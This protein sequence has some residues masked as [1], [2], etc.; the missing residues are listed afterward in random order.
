[1]LLPEVAQRLSLERWLKRSVR[2]CEYTKSL[3]N[4]KKTVELLL[5]LYY[6]SKIVISIAHNL[7]QHDRM[8]HIEINRYFI[9]EKLEVGTICLSFMPSGQQTID[10]LTKRLAR[11]NLEHLISKLGM[12]DIDALT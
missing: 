1:M 7:N 11:P 4:S 8:K 5:K 3:K 10:I 2:Y 12:I 9:K 6:N